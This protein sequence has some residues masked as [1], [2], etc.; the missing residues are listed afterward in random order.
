MP[1]NTLLIRALLNLYSFYGNE[2]K[3]QCPTGSG[4]YMTLF[5][6]AQEIP[7]GWPVRSCATRLTGGQVRRDAQVPGRSALARSDS[8]H[9]SFMVTME[10]ELGA[11]IRRGGRV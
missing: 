9:R 6:V 11:S 2:F 5:E 8:L 10:R 3:I 4:Q 7:A 1:V